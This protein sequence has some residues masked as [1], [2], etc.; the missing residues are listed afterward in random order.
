MDNLIC[1]QNKWG[2]YGPC[3][4]VAELEEEFPN[5]YLALKISCGALEDNTVRRFC[6]ANG[7]FNAKIENHWVFWSPAKRVNFFRA[8]GADHKYGVDQE[9]LKFIAFL[10]EM[11]GVLCVSKPE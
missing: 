8:S 5:I 1:L 7:V 4:G 11:R 2:I 10:D 9:R 6:A 3:I